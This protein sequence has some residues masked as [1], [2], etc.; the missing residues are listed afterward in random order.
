MTIDQMVGFIR[1]Y[2][3]QTHHGKE[4]DI[5]FRELKK[6]DQSPEDMAMMADLVADHVKGRET[7]RALVAAKERYVQGD[8]DA[9]GAIISSMEF[10]VNFY[11][12]HIEKEDKRYF[13]PVMRYFT[14]NEQDSLLDEGREFDRKMTHKKYERVVVDHESTAGITSTKMKSNWKDFL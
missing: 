2:A 7:T 3:D 9:L 13:I 12:K 10:L 14:K 6:K 1:V 5:L 11:P 8:K 4:E